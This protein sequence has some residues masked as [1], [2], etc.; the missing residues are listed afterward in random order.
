V[1]KIFKDLYDRGYI[2]K[3]EYSGKYCRECEAF[4]TESQLKEGK[5][6]DCGRE[7]YDAKEEAY[8]FRM[9]EFSE[10]LEALL[11]DEEKEFLEPQSR[12][13]E[14]VNNFIRPGL[15]DLCVSRTS[16]TWG[17]PVTFDDR[18]VV[19]VWI[20]ALSNY[21]TA[22]GYGNGRY[23]DFAKYWPA[24]VHMMAKEI[25]RF[26]SMIWP[27]MLMAL[28]SAASEKILRSRLDYV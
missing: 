10:K 24:D 21:I 6:P 27:A 1:P 2:Y 26:H 16:F 17:V 12:V 15:E 19:Y 28:E 22:L 14:M 13:N 4:W 7:V 23:D 5:C 8:F 25:V 20:D 18:H 9:S 3:G 11:T